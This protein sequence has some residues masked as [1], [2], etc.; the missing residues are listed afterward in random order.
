MVD[1]PRRYSVSPGDDGAYLPSLHFSGNLGVLNGF[2]PLPTVGGVLAL[3]LNAS[4]HQLF[5]PDGH[6]F[7]DGV[8]GWGLGARVGIIRESF[9]LPGVSVSVARR[10]TGSASFGEMAAGGPFEGE[11]DLELTSV[12]G[13]IGKDILGVGLMAGGGWDRLSGDG[14]IRARVSPTGP[15]S[16]AGTSELTSE[17]LTFFGGGSVTYLILQLSVELGW[18]RALDPELPLVPEGANFPANK[19]YF[20]S[21]GARVTF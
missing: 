1:V 2:S 4:M 19:A 3:D 12:R 15:E 13:L 20:G 10:W 14:D 8:R 18:S 17:R 16:M 11:F 6:G 5:L 21:L 9:S 7:Q